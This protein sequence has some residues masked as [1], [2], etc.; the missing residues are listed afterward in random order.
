M[1]YATNGGCL[2]THAFKGQGKPDGMRKVTKAYM[3]AAEP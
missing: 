3:E 2:S 1:A